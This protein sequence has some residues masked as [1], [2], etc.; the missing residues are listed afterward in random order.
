MIPPTIGQ[1]LERLELSSQT[2][3]AEPTSATDLARNTAAVDADGEVQDEPSTPLVSVEKSAM[4][5]KFEVLLNRGQYAAGIEQ[6]ANCLDGVVR[7]EQL[8]SVYKPS[9]DYSRANRFAARNPIGLHPDSFEL[10]QL[11]V[12]LH[13]WTDGAFDITAGQ[14]SEIWGFSRREGRKP[15]DE[16]IARALSLVGTEKL[17]LAP[18]LRE[19]H[20]KVGGLKLNPGGIG[21]GFALDLAA[22]QLRQ[23]GVRDFAMHGGQSSILTAGQR[24]HPAAD[25]GWRVAIKHPLNPDVTLGNVQLKDLGLGTSGSGKQFF[26]FRGKR[27]SHIIDPRSGQPAAG[28]L[29]TT[30][31]HPSAAI[32]DALATALFVMGP[33]EAV[34]FCERNAISAVLILDRSGGGK[35]AVETINLADRIWTPTAR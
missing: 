2:S 28:L 19:V 34:A 35:A 20:F 5:C 18:E 31:L 8:L 32:A 23:N 1:W 27:Y 6:A 15:D 30:V 11:A 17:S 25:T 10:L 14:L 7:L 26:H 29:S 3:I 22:L 24:Q 21:K 9:S 12:A 4:A 13:D 16:E 33:K